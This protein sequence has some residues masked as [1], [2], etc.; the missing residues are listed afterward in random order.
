M[1]RMILCL[2]FVLTFFCFSCS[3]KGA[4]KQIIIELEKGVEDSIGYSLFVDSIERINLETTDESLIGTITDM[5]ITRDCIY[6]FD[7]LQQTIWIFDSD[8]RY[9]NKISRQGEGPEEYDYISQFEYDD[10]KKHI[11]VL[12]PARKSL[13]FYTPEGKYLKTVH[14]E[15]KP[16]DFKVCPQGGF[17]LS[18][19]GLD[20]PTAGIYFT[21]DSG[22]GLKCLVKRHDNH[23][24]YTTS[25]WELCSYEDAI[26]FMAPNFDNILYHFKDRQ[27]SVEYPFMVMP[28]LKHD[29]KRSVSLQHLEDFIRTTYLEGDKWIWATYWSASGGLRV[30]VYSKETDKYWVGKTIVNDLDSSGIGRKTSATGNNRFVTWQENENPNGNPTI[31]I[32]HLNTVD[33]RLH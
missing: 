1:D 27:L 12:S 11:I 17:I 23:L 7:E 3:E 13:L 4:Q 15:M 32:L 31:Q 14:L 16:D 26:C 30:F 28:K 24:V 21:D 10:R 19:S 8:G 20:A 9:R 2:L 29:Y 5:A 22:E 25:T 6:I 18:N 33:K